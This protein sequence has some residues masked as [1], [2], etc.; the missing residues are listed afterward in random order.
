MWVR[1]YMFYVKYMIKCIKKTEVFEHSPSREKSG[2]PHSKLITEEQFSWGLSQ[3]IG[4]GSQ[5]PD[6][7]FS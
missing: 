4:E 3:S 1:G 7:T 2:F 5:T 6:F